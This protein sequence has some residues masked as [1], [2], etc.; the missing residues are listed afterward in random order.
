[1]A[2]RASLFW[3][4]QADG[5]GKG[6]KLAAANS[7]TGFFEP[8]QR[9]IK[10]RHPRRHFIRCSV[11]AGAFLHAEGLGRCGLNRS[12]LWGLPAGQGRGPKR[13][14]LISGDIDLAG[15]APGRNFRDSKLDEP[16]K[17][18]PSRQSRYLEDL[19]RRSLA[20]GMTC[21][22]EVRDSVDSRILPILLK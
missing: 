12:S 8:V 2:R 20:E 18:G 16:Q 5:M 22:Q 3:A 21:E 15:L 10:I 1:M 13:H 19:R 11:N 9:A 6:P 7:G 14:H 4:R 17:M